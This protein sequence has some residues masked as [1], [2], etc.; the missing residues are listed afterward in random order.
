MKYSLDVNWSQLMGSPAQ[1]N[2][3]FDDGLPFGLTA[4]DSGAEGSSDVG[5][6]LSVSSLTF[7][8]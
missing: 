5:E 7:T 8:R 6:D 4:P 1:V 2:P 3:T